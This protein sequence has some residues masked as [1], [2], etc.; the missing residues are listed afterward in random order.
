M[1]AITIDKHSRLPKRK[2][3][4]IRLSDQHA[5]TLFAR[6]GIL[7]S[8]VVTAK[9]S[10]PSPGHPGTTATLTHSRRAGTLQE[11]PAVS[12]LSSA[13]YKCCRVSKVAIRSCPWP[14]RV[15]LWVALLHEYRGGS[16][17]VH[18]WGAILQIKPM[19][20]H[21]ATTVFML[22]LVAPREGIAPLPA[23]ISQLTGGPPFRAE[24]GIAR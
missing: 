8:N 17:A 10:Y 11:Q 1:A 22:C 16:G 5:L 13:S 14:A 20:E 21:V 19:A 7:G 23:T 9:S 3:S 4:I 24:Q 12:S 18:V 2:Q 6:V 15:V